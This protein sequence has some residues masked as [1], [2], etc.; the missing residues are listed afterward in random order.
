MTPRGRK[1]TAARGGRTV[2]DDA[3]PPQGDLRIIGGDL[4]G[5]R[6]RYSGDP[7]TRPMK[8]RVREAVFN[9]LGP[10][11]EGTLAIDL[12][13]G[14]GALAF[15]AL[16]RGAARAILIEQHIPTAELARQSAA[17]LELS[18]R[19]EVVPGNTFIWARR[20]ID[21]ASLPI[22]LPWLVFCSPPYDF[23]IERA[24]DMRALLRRLIGA[25]P[26]GSTFVVEADERCDFH[27]LPRPGAW[28]LRG[29]PPALVG[30]AVKGDAVS[31]LSPR[32][33]P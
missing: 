10:T 5:R 4:R 27:S 16:S 12:F 7:R 11:V 32:S 15:E 24:D 21:Q 3:Q 33:T 26:A 30:I 18:D 19:V 28:D 9:L 6:L 31:P 13:A 8:D 23:F 1:T 20:A 25:A 17:D 2:A 29:Y 14:T 22:D